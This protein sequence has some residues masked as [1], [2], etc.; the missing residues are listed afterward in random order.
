MNDEKVGSVIAMA[1]NEFGHMILAEENGPLKLV[2]DKDK[3]GIPEHVRVY[4]EEVK[5]VQGF[6][7][8]TAKSLRPV[9]APRARH[10]I[11]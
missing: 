1:F 11:G 5:S 4:C 7:L 8:S 10:S 9:K 2:F 6:W 3:D